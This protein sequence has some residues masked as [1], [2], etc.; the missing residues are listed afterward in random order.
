MEVSNF[1]PKGD[2]AAEAVGEF[3]E[4]LSCQRAWYN[5]IEQ[6]IFL[7]CNP[8]AGS[9]VSAIECTTST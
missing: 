1:H 9:N 5:S 2:V 3:I 7:F 8:D 6:Q 4:A